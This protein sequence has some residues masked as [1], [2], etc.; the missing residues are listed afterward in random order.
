MIYGIDIDG[1]LCDIHKGFFDMT[2]K[3]SIEHYKNVKPFKKV[4]AKINNLYEEGHVITIIT[5]RS[6]CFRAV[7]K[8]WLHKN[9]VFY[10]NLSMGKEYAECYLGDNYFN[11]NNLG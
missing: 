10:D 11:I 2:I 3:E 6:T 7:T 4:I 5:A 9:G 8:E 1:T